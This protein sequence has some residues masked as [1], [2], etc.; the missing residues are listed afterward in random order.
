MESELLDSNTIEKFSK[1]LNRTVIIRDN[2]AD[3][4][5][6]DDVFRYR[7]HLPLEDLNPRTVLDLGCNIG[8]TTAYYELLWP[9]AKTFALDIDKENCFLAAANTDKA[10]I[11]HLGVSTKTGYRS[12][13]SELDPDTYYLSK[14]GNILVYCMSLDRI[15]STLG[16]EIIDFC[17]MDIEGEEI[18]IIKDDKCRW[19]GKIRSLLVEVHNAYP[20]EKIEKALKKK[21]YTVEY[22]WR[23]WAS[24]WATKSL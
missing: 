19:P 10:V 14:T 22:N 20:I 6:F 24:L 23:H 16:N 1:D 12:Y 2:E 8:L 5:T 17:K 13:D 9:F 18:D 15:I 3:T 4:A 21:G 11:Q 7:Y